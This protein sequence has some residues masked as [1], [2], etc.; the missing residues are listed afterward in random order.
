VRRTFG[1]YASVTGALLTVTTA[2]LGAYLVA[3]VSAAV[4]SPMSSAALF[5]TIPITT[6]RSL[7]TRAYEALQKM[8]LVVFVKSKGIYSPLPEEIEEARGKLGR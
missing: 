2:A 1:V 8:G 5:S 6:M 4:T 3:E 7:A